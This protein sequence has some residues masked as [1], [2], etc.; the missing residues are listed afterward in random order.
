M[1]FEHGNL[2]S[3][4]PEHVRRIKVAV[5]LMVLIGAGFN[6]FFPNPISLSPGRWA[7]IYL[8]ITEILG[9]YLSLIH[10]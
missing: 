1:K 8:R 4:D 6:L 7:W 2:F 3:I 9:P 5:G 10:I